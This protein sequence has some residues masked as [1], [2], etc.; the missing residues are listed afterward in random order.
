M[1]EVKLLVRRITRIEDTEKIVEA[2]DAPKKC[3]ADDNL[4]TGAMVVQP[5]L[6]ALDVARGIADSNDELR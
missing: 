4:N 2:L 1:F 3:F 5:G 6:G